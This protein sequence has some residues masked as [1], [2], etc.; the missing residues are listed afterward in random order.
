MD[1]IVIGAGVVGNGIAVALADQGRKVLLIERDWRQPDRIVGELLQPGGVAA[2][3]ILGLEG[4][5][6]GIDVV[7]C[8]VGIDG[9]ENRGYAVIRNNETVIVEYPKDK[10]PNTGVSFHHGAFINKLREASK[11]HAK[12]GCF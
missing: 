12:Y 11:D 1:C 9:I 6:L 8:L 7:D 5:Q 2:L 3:Q 10:V 4:F